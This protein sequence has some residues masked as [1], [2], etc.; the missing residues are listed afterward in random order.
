MDRPYVFINMAMTV[1]GKITSARREYPKFTTRFDRKSMDRLRAQAD[2]LLVGAGTMRA[3]NPSLAVRD[4]EM[5]QYRQRLGLPAGLIRVLVT[6]SAKLP[7]D[8]R[9]FGEDDDAPR[10]IATVEAAPA[11][12]V[13]ALEKQA[14]IWRVGRRRVDLAELLRRLHERGVRRLLCEGGG[15]LNWQL[16]RDDLV[17]ELFVTVAPSLL[18]GR[19]APTLLEGEGFAMADQRRLRLIDMHREGDELY[20]RYAVVR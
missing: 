8:S 5:R 16:F 7:G 12:D 4:P 6:A 3:D 14:E 9:F 2:A 13:A 19:D 15:R 18:G 17:D 20:C 10:I 1:D 11:N